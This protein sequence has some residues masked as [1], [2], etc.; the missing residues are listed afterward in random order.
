M[1]DCGNI[2]DFYEGVDSAGGDIRSVPNIDID[3]LKAIADN[4]PNCVAFNTLGYLK[5]TI[6]K[7]FNPTRYINSSGQGIYVK[8]IDTVSKSN[9]TVIL[10]VYK[11]PYSLIEQLEAVQSQSIIPDNIIIWKNAAEGI[12]L[13]VIPEHLMKNVRVINSSGNYGVWARFSVAL[14]ANTEFIAV[15]DDDTIPQYNWFKNCLDTMKVKEGLLGTIGIRFKTGCEYAF[16]RRYGWHGPNNDIE[17]VDIV[18]HAWFFKRAWLSH[19]WNF[20]PDYNIH[21]KCGEDIAF[22]YMLQRAGIKTYVP[23]HPENDLSMYGS[24]PTTALLYGTDKN[25]AISEA[26]GMSQHFTEVL[27][28]FI[29]NLGFKTINNVAHNISY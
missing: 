5:S 1:E 21:L 8:R 4:D 25:A 22:S 28:H 10:T 6:S 9:I 13:P 11:R 27:K 16:H 17:E 12:E 29:V 2:W 14:L 26:P 24:K 18:G 7:P 3:K 20:M 23:P 19:L 15:F